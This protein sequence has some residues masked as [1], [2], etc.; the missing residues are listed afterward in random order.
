MAPHHVPAGYQHVTPYLCVDGAAAAIDLYRDLFGAAER[1]RMD[2]PD[3]RVGHAE[4]Q[5]GDSVVMVS[6]E[7]P[8]IGVRGPG[9]YGGSAQWLSVYVPDVDAV[10]ARAVAAGATVE[11]EVQD[12]FY[13]DRSGQIRD[14]F[15]HVWTIA[16]HV[17]DVAPEEMERRAA[18]A[19]EAGEG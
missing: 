8:E 17:E 5:I 11:R 9:A 6:D 12:Q 1:M 2:G 19:W 4:L 13:G 16:T 3:G 15:G 18:A 14:P 7:H 10:V